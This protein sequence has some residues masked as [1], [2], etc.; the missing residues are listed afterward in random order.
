VADLLPISEDATNVGGRPK[1]FG[2]GPVHWMAKGEPGYL[3]DIFRRVPPDRKKGA[4]GK[5]VTTPTV[6]MSEKEKTNGA[7]GRAV[8]CAAESS[9]GRFGRTAQVSKKKR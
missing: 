7:K 5:D 2:D 9:L 3:K 6:S 1:C 4:R 8:V